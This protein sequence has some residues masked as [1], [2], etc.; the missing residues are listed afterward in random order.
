M[1]IDNN[2]Y[3]KFRALEFSWPIR[4]YRYLDLFIYYQLFME[5]YKKQF[6]RDERGRREEECHI[7]R[8]GG[9]RRREEKQHF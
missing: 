5:S 4:I 7:E 6:K 9:G 2:K 8:N 1:F 3:P